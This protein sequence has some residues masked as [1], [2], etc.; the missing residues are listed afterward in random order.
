MVIASTALIVPLQFR[1]AG[2]LLLSI[3]CAVLG[4]FAA[5]GMDRYGRKV[6]PTEAN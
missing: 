4:F 5:W 2:E 1:D 3:G 6:K